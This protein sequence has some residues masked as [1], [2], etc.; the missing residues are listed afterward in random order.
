MAKKMLLVPEVE[1]QRL[2]QCDR[3]V[4]TDILGQVKHPN[5][6]ELVK[7]YTDM[8]RTLQDP[9]TSDQTKVAK[10][11]E[12]MNDFSVL[13]NRVTG[14]APKELSRAN[15]MNEEED[16][17]VKD[18]V[19]LMPPT[20]QKHARQLLLRLIKRKDLISWNDNG[21][22]TIEG[23]QIAGSHIGDLVSDVLRTRKATTPLRS[24]FLDVLAKANVPDE[25]VRNKTA[26]AQFRKMKNGEVSRRPPGLPALQQRD[27]DDENEIQ[28]VQSIR[29]K[30]KRV[31]KVK[32]LGN[33]K[34]KNL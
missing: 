33:I 29:K 17:T 21:E 24:S 31:P 22:V 27:I 20:L 18:A 4:S 34:W 30:K 32:R 15:E 25:F 12:Y 5:E 26:L 16:A 10:H 19:E 11:V 14:N 13:R 6:R 23:K 9:S 7:T 1:F 28:L 3:K 8:E 2:Q